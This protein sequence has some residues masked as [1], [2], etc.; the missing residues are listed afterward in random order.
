MLD[1]APKAGDQTFIL[2]PTNRNVIGDLGELDVPSTDNP[3]NQGRQGVQVLLVVAVAAR[4]QGVRERA[5][6]GTIGLEA[7]GHG[8]LLSSGL[9]ATTKGYHCLSASV[10]GIGIPIL[11]K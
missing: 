11:N 10:S 6:D 7:D 8:L 9:V 5:F 1:P 2:A 4:V 3:T